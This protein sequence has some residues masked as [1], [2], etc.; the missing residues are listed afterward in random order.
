MNAP[1]PHPFDE[2]MRE[3]LALARARRFRTAPNP[4]VGAVLVRDGRIVAR[5]SHKGAGYPHAEVEALEDARQKGV[6]PSGCV[7]VVTLEPCSH[8]GRTPPCT[9]A[10]LGAGVRHVVI[11]AMDPTPEAGGGAK[12]LRA[13]GVTVETGILRRE[14]EDAISDFVT[15]RTT[16]YPYVILKLAATLD[17]RI[18]TRTGHSRWISGEA[19]RR[20]VHMLRSLADAVMVGG[21]TFHHDNPGLNYRP[22][23]GEPPVEK[24]PLAVV[25]SSRLPDAEGAASIVRERPEQAFFW[26]TVASAASPKAEAL[27]KKGVTVLG[28]PLSP[29]S[30][31]GFSG[32][33]AGG[34]SG[35]GHGPRAELDLAEGLRRLRA[36]SGVNHVVCEGGGRLGLSLLRAGLVGEFHLHLSPR[37]LGD[38]EATPLFSGFSPLQLD[39]ALPLRFTGTEMLEGDLLLTLRPLAVPAAAK[40]G[41]AEGPDYAD[42]SDYTGHAGCADVREGGV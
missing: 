12:I 32:S 5:G 27:R 17:G 4:G 22:V 23:A 11:G 26:T 37:I 18:A 14:C 16:P 28:L 31:A 38:N 29:S 20:R 15:L 21:N 33:M 24:Q 7:M 1:A 39:E 19:S 34:M 6:D 36:E 2:A 41:T 13:R 30:V 3:A 40:K 25:V 10:L 35:G 42:R 8:H 9:E